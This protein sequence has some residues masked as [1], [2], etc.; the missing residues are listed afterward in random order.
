MAKELTDILKA[1]AQVRDE[2]ASQQNTA[3]RVGGVLTDLAQFVGEA[4]FAAGMTAKTTAAGVS[5]LIKYYDADG[6]P[7]TNARI[8]LREL[9][10]SP[11][12]SAIFVCLFC[13][14]ISTLPLPRYVTPRAAR[15]LRQNNQKKYIVMINYQVIPRRHLQSGKKYYYAQIAKVQ[16]FGIDAIIEVISVRTTIASADVKAVLD[17][18]QNVT[19]RLVSEGQSLRL[20][21]LGSFRP[22]LTSKGKDEPEQVKASDI[23][24]VRVRFTRGAWL[25]KNLVPAYCQFRR[26]DANGYATASTPVE[27]VGEA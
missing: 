10:T 5:L 15:L 7:Y 12:T 16:P 11:L 25:S 13:F 18:L 24:S 8:I 27:T 6:Q 17:A 23:K 14:S 26:T 19:L 22:T 9:T 21:D 1:A 20:G 3:T 4:V 2:T